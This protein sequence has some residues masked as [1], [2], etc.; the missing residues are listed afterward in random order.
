MAVL[1]ILGTAL[2]IIAATVAYYVND[3]ISKRK[4]LAGLVNYHS[5]RIVIKL[6]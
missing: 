2:L 1:Q 5:R 4:Q 6:T 3:L